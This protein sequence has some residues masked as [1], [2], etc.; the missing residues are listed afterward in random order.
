MSYEPARWWHGMGANLNFH[1]RA[2][3][4][5]FFFFLLG[6]FLGLLLWLLLRL[7]L[8]LLLGLVLRLLLIGPASSSS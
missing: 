1:T 2:D 4:R 7:L 5:V 3:A 6:F 8:E